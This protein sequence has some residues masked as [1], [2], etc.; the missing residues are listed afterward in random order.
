MHRFEQNPCRGFEH[1][2]LIKHITFHKYIQKTEHDTLIKH[3]TFHKLYE[4]INLFKKLV[5]E[6]F[7]ILTILNTC[8]IKTDI[9]F[10]CWK[11]WMAHGICLVHI[12]CYDQLVIAAHLNQAYLIS[13]SILLFVVSHQ[14]KVVSFLRENHY[15]SRTCFEKI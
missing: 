13:W 11:L 8:L 15:L 7:I 10:L 4:H 1:D 3:I 12:G 9:S 6:I 5:S 14:N 2:T